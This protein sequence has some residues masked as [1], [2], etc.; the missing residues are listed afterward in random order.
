MQP[1]TAKGKKRS[2]KEGHAKAQTVGIFITKEKR[3]K[4]KGRCSTDRK[5]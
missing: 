2:E 5:Y 4:R 3:E 1:V